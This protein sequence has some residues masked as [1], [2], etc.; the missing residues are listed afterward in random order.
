MQEPEGTL[1]TPIVSVIIVNWNGK[2]LLADC[3]G[4]LRSQTYRDHETILVDNGSTDGSIDFVRENF[5]DVRLIPLAENRGFAGG[6]NAGIQASSGRFVAL[7]NN[8]TRA[9]ANWLAALVKAAESEPQ[10]GMWASKILSFDRRD[11]IDNVGLL[12][13]WDGLA[14]GKG[15][16]E[17]DCGQYDRSEEALFPS[18][19]ACLYRR[20]LL[21]ETGLFDED[22]FAYADDV[23]MGLRGRLAG[24]GCRYVPAAVVY[25]KY[26]SSSSAYSPFKAFLVERN[27]IWVLVKYYPFELVLASPYFT[28][29]RLVLSLYGALSGRGASGK[30]ADQHSL[31]TA[32]GILLKAWGAALAGMPKALRQRRAFSRRKRLDRKG[33]YQLHRRFS[34]STAE[35][36]LK[37]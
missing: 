20:T 4:S 35:I 34:L 37:E 26:S 24:W 22:F 27:R 21:E 10:T 6:N 1:S 7:L 25:H 15:R 31:G 16:L 13:Y 30:F 9:D 11:V 2:H 23:D 8:D 12:L 36:A 5:P 14:R 3:L 32:V 29:K 18:G 19:C 33:F 28:L 17:V